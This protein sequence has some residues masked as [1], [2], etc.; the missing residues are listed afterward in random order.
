MMLEKAR[1]EKRKGNG[2]WDEIRCE[3]EGVARKRKRKREYVT[4]WDGTEG[5]RRRQ[6]SRRKGYMGKGRRAASFSSPLIKFF[7]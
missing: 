5:N 1:N 4:G 6:R 2:M 7:A 3:K